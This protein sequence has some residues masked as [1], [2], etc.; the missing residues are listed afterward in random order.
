MLRTGQIHTLTHGM[1]NA[2]LAGEWSSEPLE[3]R[4]AEAL[5]HPWEW[6]R[7]VVGN[8]RRQYPAPPA[9]GLLQS[10]Q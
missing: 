5:G 10:H 6:R 3:A 2:L 8:L 1:A 4:L 9:Y 7:E